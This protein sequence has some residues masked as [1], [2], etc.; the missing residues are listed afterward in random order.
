MPEGR[1]VCPTDC[2]WFF[3]PGGCRR[4][5]NCTAFIAKIA[6]INAVRKAEITAGTPKKANKKAAT[7]V[8]KKD[9]FEDSISDDEKFLM[10]RWDE[11]C[12]LSKAGEG[13][14]LPSGKK[15]PIIWGLKE[16][17][18]L[19]N[20]SSTI[21]QASIPTSEESSTA[22]GSAKKTEAKA[23]D[24]TNS[25]PSFCTVVKGTPWSEYP[26]DDEP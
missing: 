5:K 23:D 15:V 22:T 17:D 12:A 20:K 24:T 2:I 6:S 10:Q 21:V 25:F 7:A 19:H 3:K 16:W 11:I 18:A 13:D 14:T 8:A 4:G 9:V 1:I 26:S